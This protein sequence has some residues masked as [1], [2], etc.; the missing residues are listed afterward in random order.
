M[1]ALYVS[2]LVAV[3]IGSMSG[4]EA[5]NYTIH[6]SVIFARTGERTPLLAP[7]TTRLTSLGAQQMNSLGAYF[8]RRYIT[9]NEEGSL[10]GAGPL[11][12]LSSWSLD[13][14]QVFVQTTDALYTAQ[15]A[16]AFMQALYPPQVL[17]NSTASYLDPSSILANNTYVEAPLNGYQYGIINTVSQ[18]DPYS[19]YLD[20][21]V[22]CPNFAESAL[23]YYTSEEFNETKS[24]TTTM[25]QSIGHALPDSALPQ[26]GWGYANAYLLWDYVSYQNAHDPAAKAILD[27]PAYRGTIAQMGALASQKQSQVYGDLTQSHVIPGDRIRAIAGKT[28]AARM[29]GMLLDNMASLGKANKLSLFVGEY[30][31]M[32]SLFSLL[33]LSEVNEKFK[34][35]P[36]FASAIAFELFSWTGNDAANVSGDGLMYPDQDALW[37]RFLYVNG[38]LASDNE[39]QSIK[40]YP[41]FQRGPSETDM[42]WTEFEALV[43]KIMMSEI[44]DWCTICSSSSVFC[45]G[46]VGASTSSSSSSRKSKNASSMKPEVAGVI[47]AAVTIGTFGIALILA[48]LFGGVR[49][50]RRD[51]A[52]PSEL[53]GFKGSAKLAS[54]QDLHLPKNAAPIGISIAAFDEDLKKGHERV[55][56]WELNDASSKDTEAQRNTFGSLGGSTVASSEPDTKPSHERD[57]EDDRINPFDYPVLVRENV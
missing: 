15:S 10:Q 40:S 44:S 31:P 47:G 46:L 20:G 1:L 7:D 53:G 57:E 42:K 54:D 14:A 33:E 13:N 56:S 41:I 48:M 22:N 35:I 34:H 21:A 50:S 2:S 16:T 49:F 28:L 24:R 55:G 30:P 39:D 37:V 43:S 38:S 3:W 45:P 17:P 27:G 12:G 18:Y 26:T 25:Y 8:R 51:K 19:A 6:A 32:L 36:P 29:V 52:K 23:R 5:Q 9:S 4:V 11:T